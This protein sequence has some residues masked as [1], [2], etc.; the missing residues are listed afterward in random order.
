MFFYFLDAETAK[1]AIRNLDKHDFHGRSLRVA[2]ADD[3]MDSKDNAQGSKQLTAADHVEL[4]SK[5]VNLMSHQQKVEILA[6]MKVYNI[7]FTYCYDSRL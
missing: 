6:Q 5:T 3:N 4:I 2:Y 1:S 7:L